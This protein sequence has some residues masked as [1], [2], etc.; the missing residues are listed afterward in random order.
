MRRL[1]LALALLLTAY[2]AAGDVAPA[3][4][5]TFT[6]GY[7]SG[8]VRVIHRRVDANDI[9]AV[10]LYLLGGSAQLN[11]QNA[12]IEALLLR[13][14]EYGTARYPGQETRIA[15]ARTGSRT[16]LD[17]DAD[18]TLF[19]FR[20]LRAEF[21]STWAVFA[22]RVM[23]PALD[24]AGIELVRNRM[25]IARRSRTRNPDALVRTLMDSVAF[26]AHPYRHDPEG[27]ETSLQGITAAALRAWH[28][29]QFVTSR[30]LLVVVGDV[31]REQ[32]E[33]AIQR[34]LALLPA[35]SYQWQLPPAVTSPKASVTVVE[36]QLPTN[37]ILGYYGGPA[38]SH[39]DYLAFVV[40]TRLMGG[41]AHT[42]IRSAGLSYVADA[43]LLERA[44]PTGGV[45]VSTTRPD[46]AMGVFRFTT[47][48]IGGEASFPRPLLNDWYDAWRP[49]LYRMN[50]SN[51]GQ[52]EFLARYEL[53]HG[54]WQKGARYMEDLRNVTGYDIK[55]VVRQY[56]KNIRYVYLG[57][58]SRVPWKQLGVKAP[59]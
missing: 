45:Y 46:T 34:T 22:E 19:G 56:V 18:W 1:L 28:E 10:N 41:I 47:E 14:S 30:M 27:T 9:V 58:G 39:R 12:G 6:T 5:D 44:A 13:A 15:L 8:G 33:A 50:E 25:L 29:A 57:D 48:L 36:Q 59:R 11:A 51:E 3:A 42:G 7:T 40:A 35:G 21:D 38:A 26:E 31:T 24:S 2:P 49:M 32:V 52:A 17:P 20:A 54:G 55:R 53:L 23:H 4:T 37:Y 16:V 43:P